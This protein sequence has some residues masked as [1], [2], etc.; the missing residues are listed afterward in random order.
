MNN[1]AVLTTVVSKTAVPSNLRF[2]RYGNGPLPVDPL[3][4]ST[5]WKSISV[6]RYWHIKCATQLKRLVTRPWRPIKK[7]EDVSASMWRPVNMAYE[8]SIA[9]GHC[10]TSNKKYKKYAVTTVTSEI[11]DARLENVRH[12]TSKLLVQGTAWKNSTRIRDISTH[13]YNTSPPH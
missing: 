4:H 1:S 5:R 2:L 13:T 10:H 7:T 3:E 6:Q 8:L 9:L 12:G 11:G